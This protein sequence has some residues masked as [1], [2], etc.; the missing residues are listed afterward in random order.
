MFGCIFLRKKTYKKLIKC[1]STRVNWQPCIHE[2]FV[3][4]LCNSASAVSCKI[5]WLKHSF[6]SSLVL[7]QSAGRHPQTFKPMICLLYL[8]FSCSSLES[9]EV[10]CHC[11]CPVCPGRV[12]LLTNQ[13]TVFSTWNFKMTQ[14]GDVSS[15]SL[16]F[17][18]WLVA[19]CP[20]MTVTQRD[21]GVNLPGEMNSS[22][23]R[24]FG[25]GQINTPH[26]YYWSLLVT[27]T[28]SISMI[29]VHCSSLYLLFSNLPCR[30]HIQET[31][32]PAGRGSAQRRLQPVRKNSHLAPHASLHHPT[33]VSHFSCAPSLAPITPL[34]L[35]Y[36]PPLAIWFRSL[37]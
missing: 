34:F 32:L 3:S 11:V 17:K 33:S 8:V 27:T 9:L 29:T 36:P 31:W 13:Y 23:C 30:T 19:L 28:F 16:C 12:L 18:C 10:T 25:L 20:I 26:A 4:P 15:L 5:D 35:C 7:A 21:G 24:C 22:K 37:S 14:T 2:C 6:Y 1:L